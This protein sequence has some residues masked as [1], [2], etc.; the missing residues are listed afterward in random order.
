[1]TDLFWPGDH[2]AATLMSG[3]AFFDALV[4]VENAWLAALVEHDVAPE[5][6]AVDLTSLVR[7]GDEQTVAEGAEQD[8]NPV[9]GVVAMLRSRAPDDAGR[10]LHRGLTSQDVVDSALM[11]C[12]RDALAAVAHHLATQVRVLAGQAE[13][14]RS[15][16]LLTRTLTQPALPGTAGLKFAVWLNSV[17][18]SA[19]N[20][21]A[22]P[23]LPVQVGGAAGTLAAATELTG[24]PRRAFDLAEA[25]ADRL[26]LRAAYPWHTNRSTLT[27][28]A[29]AMVTCCDAWGRIANEVATASRPE[30]GELIE[31]SGGGSSTMPH[32]SNPVLAVLLRRAALTAPQLGAILHAASA[33]QVDERA[34]GAWHAEWDALRTLTRHTVV[35]ASQA[36][37]L[38]T[39]LRV[40]ASNAAAN[41]TA[42][43]GIYSEQQTMS[44]LVGRAPAST[45]LGAGD[46]LIDA[47]LLRASHYLEESQ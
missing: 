41:L 9:T 42:A 46:E 13:N 6:A 31:A 19:E 25:L 30:I 40:N 7:A 23:T 32:K 33:A 36:T 15:T 21:A 18:D 16:A 35:A 20:L 8:G 39:A 38:L 24:S 11:L 3:R 27:R 43:Q 29:D 28:T 14:H 2:R 44:T 37:D 22:L 4:A 26:G 1:M 45:Y 12:T 47:A 5:S 17:L 10:W 34:D